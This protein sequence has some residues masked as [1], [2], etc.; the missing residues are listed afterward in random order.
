MGWDSGGSGGG[1][2]GGG[3]NV[4]PFFAATGLTGATTP[5]RYVGGVSGAAP[6]SGTF[7]AGDYAIDATNGT[8]Y[9]CT[10][11]GSP[12]TWASEPIATLLQNTTIPALQTQVNNFGSSIQ[13][14]AAGQILNSTGANTWGSPTGALSLA[15]LTGATSASRYVGATAGGAPTTGTFIAGDYV[16]DLTGGYWVCTTGGSPGT[17]KS[18]QT[19]LAPDVMLLTPQMMTNVNAG[20]SN[21]IAQSSANL[22]PAFYEIQPPPGLPQ[23]PLTGM[24]AIITASL[25]ASTVGA[26]IYSISY[27]AAQTFTASLICQLNTAISGAATGYVEQDVTTGSAGSGAAVANLNFATTRYLVGAV[28]SDQFSPGTLKA[29]GATGSATYTGLGNMR[30]TGTALASTTSWPG[31]FTQSSVAAVNVNTNYTMIF[32][33][34]ASGK[35]RF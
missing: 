27:S 34:T 10:S 23:Y 19:P 13:P 3:G 25:A 2:G 1:G 9:V 5:S 32:G 35:F 28:G 8:V 24:A 21:L 16:V 18:V 12:G 26:A 30:W 14:T 29:R 20:S 11:G 7:I 15:G 22:L 4:Q 31:S 17:W 33:V 6:A